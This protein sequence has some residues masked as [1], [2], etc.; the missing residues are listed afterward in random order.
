MG[1]RELGGSCGLGHLLARL[2]RLAGRRRGLTDEVLMVA[3]ELVVSGMLRF[4]QRHSNLSASI[5][6]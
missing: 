2:T 3:A 6:G 5:R 1:G 4:V